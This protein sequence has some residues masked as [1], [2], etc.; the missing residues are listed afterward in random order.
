MVSLARKQEAQADTVVQ[1]ENAMRL[2]DLTKNLSTM[3]DQELVEHVRTIRENKYTIKPAV[4]KRKADV[5]K[6]EKNTG[7]RSLDKMI[8]GMSPQQIADLLKS[9]EEGNG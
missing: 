3:S 4:Q 9:L 1:P 7:V 8:A 6:K 5:V 2:T